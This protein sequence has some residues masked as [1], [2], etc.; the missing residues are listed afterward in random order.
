[1]TSCAKPPIDTGA[2]S[3]VAARKNLEGTWDLVSLDVQ[4]LDGQQRTVEAGGT[5]VLDEFGN[6]DIKY[7]IAD[8][9]LQALDSIGLKS[10]NPEI[11]TS[12]KVMIDATQQRVTFVGDDHIDRAFDPDLAARKAN[13]F[14]L[15]RMRY[16]SIEP[17]GILTLT[18][19][20]DN[21]KNAA[22]SRWRREAVP[23]ATPSATTAGPGR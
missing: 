15:E 17:S 13:P 19:R 20:Y 10:P 1:V 23:V 2:K 6:L 9:G 7:R 22:T 18:T 12:G 16:Y 3:V 8:A 21:G 11:A 14:A 4:S 5:L